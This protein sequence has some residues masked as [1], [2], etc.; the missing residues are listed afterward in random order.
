MNALKRLEKFYFDFGGEKGILGY[1]GEKRP[2]YYFAVKKTAYPVII[3]QYAIH[4]REYV[5]TFLALI[6][7]EDFCMRG[8]RGS[9]YF[10]PA[11]NPDGIN[12]AL[13]VNPLYKANAFGVDLNVNFDAEWGKGVKNVRFRG[14]ENFIGE[15]PFSESETA[16]LRDFTLK[17]KPSATVSYHT[18]GE[19]IYYYFNQ[20]GNALY[21][22]K[23]I[24]EKLAAA[25]G[26]ALKTPKGSVGGY[27]DWC[28]E[29][30]KIPAFTIEAG[31]DSLSHPIGEEFAKNIF[32][33][34]KDVLNILT[35]S[36]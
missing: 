2:I 15:K 28:I 16:A 33:K 26:Y 29:K 17:V 20:S 8:K 11:A 1:S 23:A 5:T 21:R 7:I 31:A 13:T 24:A 10:I 25:T 12:I 27:K 6:Q 18:K 14:A 32:E 4:A 19:E 35:E 3:A 34:N 30:L 36:L 22:D 9:V